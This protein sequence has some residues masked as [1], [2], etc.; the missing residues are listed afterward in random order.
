MK[1]AIVG[2]SGSGKTWL[3]NALAKATAVQAI[4]LDAIFWKPGG[5]DEKRPKVETT[6]LTEEAAEGPAWIVEGVFGD[7]LMPFLSSAHVLIWLDPEWEVCEARLHRRGSQSKA[8]MERIQSD[9]GVAK[10]IAWASTYETRIDNMSRAGHSKIFNSFS[11]PKAI[12]RSEDDA[13]AL[14]AASAKGNF[15]ES[16]STFASERNRSSTKLTGSI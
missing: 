13:S 12:L 7:L 1:T 8:H 10:L 3:A 2:N 5:F 14:L 4:H 16:F 6:R 9:Q 15:V 11:G